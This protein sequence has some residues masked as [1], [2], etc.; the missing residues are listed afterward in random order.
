M[1]KKFL[2][3]LLLFCLCSASAL[4]QEADDEPMA[5]TIAGEYAD[6][7][8][9]NYSD[10]LRESIEERF[11][12]TFVPLQIDTT[13]AS[14]SY[15]L[16]AAANEF[17][18]IM[19]YDAQW[20]FLYF[21]Q[22]NALR[23]LPDSLSAYPNLRQY[24]TYPYAQNL[25]YNGKIRGLPRSLYAE[26]Q[27]LPGYCVLIHKSWLERLEMD[28]PKT[29]E[30]WRA[31]LGAIRDLDENV[32]PLAAQSP[33]AMFSLP[34]F[35]APFSNTWIWEPDQNAYVPG[36]YTQSYCARISVL[37]ELWDDGLLDPD[38][39]DVNCGRPT[40]IDHFL[41]RQAACIVYPT[42]SHVLMAELLHRWSQMYPDQPIED[43]VTAVF[44]P[45]DTDGQYSESHD[46]NL[47]AIY[48]GA[49]VS[50]EKLDRILSVLDYLCSSEGLTLR[51]WGLSGVDYALVGG[52]PVSLLP[53]GVTLYDKYPSYSLLRVLPN[54]DEEYMRSDTTLP[55]FAALLNEKCAQWEDLCRRQQKHWTSMKANIILTS[56]GTY[57]NP[58]LTE[59]SFRMLTA[60]EGV[61]AAFDS[62]RREFVEQGIEQ[63]IYKVTVTLR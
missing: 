31:L 46:L 42:S 9:S 24:I 30:D 18:D 20:D 5:I 4:G 60:P 43:Q 58:N 44:L 55:A 32:I 50:D 39:M 33:W 41:L 36:F 19:L 56:S 37:R 40:G 63:L 17:P 59:I 14:Y 52:E 57:F 16:R 48:F 51:R 28:E 35:Y 8:S 7:L 2:A 12:V 25:Q 3:V 53:E 47:S 15:R 29:M 6:L 62:I 1:F 34:Y 38:F 13:D 54:L 22:A 21:I 10:P 45:C 27:R 23:S 49:N 26:E 11:N 61:A